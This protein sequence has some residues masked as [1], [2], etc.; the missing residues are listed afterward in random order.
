MVYV[1]NGRCSSSMRHTW[2][3]GADLGIGRQINSSASI[4]QEQYPVAAGA[5]EPAPGTTRPERFRALVSGDR[6]VSPRIRLGDGSQPGSGSSAGSGD[7]RRMSRRFAFPEAMDLPGGV[8]PAPSR[9]NRETLPKI[10]SAGRPP[11]GRRPT[12]RPDFFWPNGREISGPDRP[13]GNYSRFLTNPHACFVLRWLQSFT[14]ASSGSPWAKNSCSWPKKTGPRTVRCSDDNRGDMGYLGKLLHCAQR[15][16]TWR[17]DPMIVVAA[18]EP[19]TKKA[20]RR[21]HVR[22]SRPREPTGSKAKD[23]YLF[24]GKTSRNITVFP[25][26][27]AARI[28]S[29]WKASRPRNSGSR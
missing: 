10:S 27:C 11:A 19:E 18:P 12:P 23:P 3:P 13:G 9:H 4:D 22:R 8:M 24:V 21:G 2:P 5:G 6:H 7:P 29:F 16:N 20:K 14:P 17:R 26:A 15:F 28:S 25:T 1:S